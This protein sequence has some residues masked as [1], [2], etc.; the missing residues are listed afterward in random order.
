MNVLAHCRVYPLSTFYKATAICIDWLEKDA[1]GNVV[2]GSEEGVESQNVRSIGFLH[3]IEHGFRVSAFKQKMMQRLVEASPNQSFVLIIDV[4][5]C[6]DRYLSTLNRED[7]NVTYMNSA[8]L[9]HFESLINFLVQ[10]NESP[11]EALSRC[12]NASTL[13]YQLAGIVIDNI[14]YYTHDGASYE[15]LFKVL[16]MLR[17]KYGCFVMTV[18]YGLDFYSGVEQQL[19]SVRQSYDI[20][21][22]L[23]MS[24]VKNMDC[25]LLRDTDKDA[26]VVYVKNSLV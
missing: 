4:V 2:L 5:S 8:S 23:P 22:R 10:L 26:R 21:T 6:W 24:Y 9:L 25:V 19:S 15:L 13:Q 11:K 20:P 16:R 1:F 17:A 18:G 7:K 14:S 3:L 12:Q